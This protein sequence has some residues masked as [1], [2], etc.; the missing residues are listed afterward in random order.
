[1]T[2]PIASLALIAAL[3]CDA[4]WAQPTPMPEAPAPSVCAER[5]ARNALL[6]EAS[7][8]ISDTFD[9]GIE[10]TNSARDRAA[11]RLDRL[12]ERGG[13]SAADAQALQDRHQQAASE[14]AAGQAEE[15]ASA[16]F[17]SAT[18]AF[19]DARARNRSAD[20]CRALIGVLTAINHVVEATEARWAFV[21]AAY[22]AEAAGRGLSLD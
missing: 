6:S 20:A 19:D 8:R 10:R 13:L 15:A 14:S 11:S 22:D 4:A 21:S 3:L 9:R 7:V 18:E 17:I 1:M 5:A 12:A 2:R 16:E